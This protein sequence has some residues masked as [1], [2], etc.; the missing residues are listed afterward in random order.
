MRYVALAAAAAAAV[1][2][3][4][5]SYAQVH[6]QRTAAKALPGLPGWTAGYRGWTKINRAPI[7]ARRSA[8]AHRGTKNVYA[9][10]R[11]RNGRYPFGTVIVKE[12]TRP[13]E[14]SV[15]VLA[16][17]RKVRGANPRHNDW[18]M[19]EWTRQSTRERFALLARGALCT[20][21]H[22]QACND[23]YVFTRR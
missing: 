11:A 19:I 15:G 4:A 13:G 6:V 3:V 16:A 12:I 14:R 20:S 18:V 7:P 22:V 5:T 17:M 8:D 23:D 2:T 21:C 9:S 10:R 1:I